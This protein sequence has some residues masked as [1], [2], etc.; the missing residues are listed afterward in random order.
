MKTNVL[1]LS[2]LLL[3][4]FLLLACSSGNNEQDY[5]RKVLANLEKIE[6]ASYYLTGAPY[7]HGDTTALFTNSSFTIE[8]N[9]PADTTIGASFINFN[10]TDTTELESCYDGTLLATAFHEHKGIMIDDFSTR[11]LEFRLVAPPFFNYA[12]SIIRY[13]LTTTD[14]IDTEFRDEGDH[15]YFKMIINE[16]KQ[17]EFFGKPYYMPDGPYNFGNPTSIYELWISKKDDL[18]YKRRREM[19]HSISV[20]SCTN[21]KI[22]ELPM[23]EINVFDYFPAD[24][25]VR[26]RQRKGSERSAQTITGQQ[27]PGWT[28]IDL[29]EKSVSLV[30]LKSKVL[31]INFTG[32]GCGPCQASIPFLKSLKSK[33][34]ADDVELVAIESWVRRPQSLKAYTNKNG[35]NYRMLGATDQVLKDYKTEGAAPVFFILDDKRVIRKV[36]N[37]YGKESTDREIVKAIEELI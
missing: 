28:L 29:N 9:N 13:V 16:D 36:I 31:L 25:E 7:Q 6:T 17:V 19:S 18:P 32:I 8:Y 3:T 23:A 10:S 33:Y 4:T 11:D 2:C 35:L 24:Y 15:Y 5:L 21:V 22:N 37:G 14:S 34:S 30:D 20:S 1:S 12:R 27:A 26:K